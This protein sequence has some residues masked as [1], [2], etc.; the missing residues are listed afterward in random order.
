MIRCGVIVMV[1]CCEQ[2]GGYDMSQE[3]AIFGDV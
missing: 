3:L 1:L 2:L